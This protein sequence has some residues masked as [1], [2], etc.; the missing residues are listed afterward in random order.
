MKINIQNIKNRCLPVMLVFALLGIVSCEQLIDIPDNPPDQIEQSQLF[1]D[2]ADIM[3]AVAGIYANFKIAGGGTSLF[4]GMVTEN[5]GMAADEMSYSYSNDFQTNTYDASYY[6]LTSMWQNP[7]SILY[8]INVCIE[9]ISGTDALSASSKESLI[10]EMKVLRAMNYFYL[11][12]LFGGVPVVTSSDYVENATVPRATEDEVYQLMISDLTDAVNILTPEYPSE[13]RARPNR[14]VAEAL[15]ARVY[16][17]HGDYE[18]AEEMADDVISSGLY[19]LTSLNDVFLDGSTEAIWQLPSVG[20]S[21]QTYEGYSLLPYSNYSA[22]SYQVSDFLLNSFED[23]DNRKTSWINASVVGGTN[24]YYFYKYKNR[25]ATATPVE[26]YEFLRL[27]EQYLIRAEA[28]IQLGGTDNLQKAAA[29][30]NVVRER[31][32]LTDPVVAGSQDQM[33]NAL[34][35]ERRH[36]LFCEWGHRWFDLRRTGR[37]DSVLGAEKSGWQS[38][39]GTL[40]IPAKEIQNNISLEQNPGY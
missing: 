24:Y 17:Y 30:I 13:G 27:A 18:K 5:M 37:M 23:G 36:E 9:G 16:L 40:P 2:S 33:M 6:G 14:Y 31:A 22:P 19:Q 32:G 39:M 25:S 7:Y 11:V 15:L 38:Y 12:N 26:G 21:S 10:A 8:Q 4:N 1:S 35:N 28:D 20:T 29:D 3:S 34:M